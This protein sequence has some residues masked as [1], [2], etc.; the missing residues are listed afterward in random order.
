MTER[1]LNDRYFAWMYQLVCHT[2]YHEQAYYHFLLNRLHEIK[3]TYI[4]PMDSNRAEDGVNLRYRFAY[5][6]SYDAA[7]IRAYLDNRDC[8]V[9]EMLIALAIKCEDQIMEDTDIGNRTGKWFWTMIENLGLG[10]LT[11]PIYNEDYVNYV[12]ERLLNR[13]YGRDGTGGLFTVR[14]CARD[15]RS[16]E[17]WYQAMYYLSEIR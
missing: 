15:M 17:F 2:G 7:L 8:S 6:H 13:E 9:L 3:F 10:G 12:I 1:E 16:V 14:N 4:H 11:D 5:E